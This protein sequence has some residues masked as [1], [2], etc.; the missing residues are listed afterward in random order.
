[1]SPSVVSEESSHLGGLLDK[2]TGP[3]TDDGTVA[4]M[5]DLEK[6]ERE[7]HGDSEY[8]RLRNEEKKEEFEAGLRYARVEDDLRRRENSQATSRVETGQ[9]PSDLNDMRVYSDLTGK[10]G[11][12]GITRYANDDSSELS[13]PPTTSYGGSEISFPSQTPRER[14]LS[15]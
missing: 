12:T 15:P 2:I 1:M 5:D 11:D 14:V 4:D 9:L 6:M 13:P 3:V 10:T 8:E 7:L